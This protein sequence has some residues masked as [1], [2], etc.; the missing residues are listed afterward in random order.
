[1]LFRSDFLRTKEFNKRFNYKTRSVLC[2]PLVHPINNEC[3][4]VVK[5]INKNIDGE[6][7]SFDLKD[8][9]IA[10]M[11]S[12]FMALSISKAQE[13]VEKLKEANAKLIK[14]N[15]SL[16]KR[17]EDEVHSNQQK[18]AVIFHQSKMASMG[19]MLSNIAHQWRQPLSTIST[20]ASGLSL[21]LQLDKISKDDAMGQLRKIVVTDRKSTRLNSS[22]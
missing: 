7:L 20:L 11:L 9:Q 14:V 5:L 19:E 22:H 17:I 3:L 8:K 18:S 21:E 2:V 16:E 10:S 6:I 13:D 15:E 12:S 1:M 4:G